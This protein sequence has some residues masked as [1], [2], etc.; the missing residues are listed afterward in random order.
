LELWKEI[1]FGSN[2]EFSVE[3]L[4][5][6]PLTGILFTSCLC[7]LNV[8]VTIHSEFLFVFFALLFKNLLVLSAKAQLVEPQLVNVAFLTE[9]DI[10]DMN[11]FLQN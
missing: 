1:D 9:D 10:L 11:E 6:R 8:I 3:F 4:F 7:T 2:F 5:E